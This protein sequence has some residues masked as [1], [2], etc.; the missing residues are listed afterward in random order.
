MSK[1]DVEEHDH[2][3]LG[4]GHHLGGQLSGGA[5][6]GVPT[7][8]KP[9]TDPV[10]G[11]QVAPNR[12]KEIAYKD[13]VYHFCSAKCMAKFNVTP[14]EY[15]SKVKAPTA[16]EPAQAG[17]VYTCPMHPEIRQTAPGSCPICGMA[18]EPVMPSLDDEE[19]PELVDFR[20]RFW[21]TLPLTAIV[22]ALAMFG[23]MLFRGAIPGQSWIEFALST[24]VVIWAGWPFFVRWA[25][26]I[27]RM[28]PNM[29]TLIGSGVMAAYG[30]S[31][32]ATIAPRLFPPS[33][34]A[35]G[36]VGVYFEAAAVIV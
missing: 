5:E 32:A 24:P 33:F 14:A 26:S 28:S 8:D 10:C 13:V 6:P 20:R 31:V 17:T 34:S 1:H 19:N 29:W 23:H 9:Y 18:L 25:Q 35:H 16:S 4:H 3:H 15:V 21:W 36:N 22:F 7:A 30:Y 11:M 27:A 2:Q 12:E